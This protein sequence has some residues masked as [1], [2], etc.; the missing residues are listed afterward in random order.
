MEEV[1]VGVAYEEEEEGEGEA[2]E[3]AWQWGF[4]QEVVSEVVD[5]HGEEGE[6]FEGVIEV[7]SPWGTPPRRFWGGHRTG[8]FLWFFYEVEDFDFIRK[9]L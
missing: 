7:G 2:S 1:V 4:G 8:I 5:D 3:G 9:F 6:Q